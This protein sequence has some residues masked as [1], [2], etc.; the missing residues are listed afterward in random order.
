MAGRTYQVRKPEARLVIHTQ[1]KLP[2]PELLSWNEKKPDASFNI[3]QDL[4]SITTL[5]NMRNPGGAWTADLVYRKAR[6]GMR[7]AGEPA[8]Y[9]WINP[10][11]IVEIQLNDSN[12]TTMIGMIEQV[13]KRR[14]V[15]SSGVRQGV[16]LS[17]R[18]LGS[19]WM[20]DALKFFPPNIAVGEGEDNISIMGKLPPGF[21]DKALAFRREPI[22]MSEFY[23][24]SPIK[25]VEYITDKM[26][27]VDIE[28]VDGRKIRDF[29]DTELS[30]EEGAK[31]FTNA[32]YA[33]EGSI[34]GL[35]EQ[36]SAKPFYEVF[37]D[38][39]NGKLI[40]RFRATPFDRNSWN[41][42]LTWLDGNSYHI[43][44]DSD[45]VNENLIRSP[46]ESY[47]IFHV[48]SIGSPWFSIEGES[49]YSLIPPLID[50]ELYK[51]LGLKFLATKC[52][53]LPLDIYGDMGTGITEEHKKYRNGL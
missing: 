16:R 21:K 4:K 27:S 36:V 32:G 42:L 45:I 28:Y 26:S 48:S 25:L 34:W 12:E 5:N 9:K 38:S 37:T 17:G 39:R 50:P 3:S 30:V 46:S 33:Y 41:N 14:V 8:L 40:L 13:Q 15:T 52:S 43:I 51:A 44:P 47:S 22:I 10:M 2:N 11:D 18:S 49:E 35:L 6:K 31:T 19:I 29:I 53:L 20:H 24:K 7:D 23:G 1:T